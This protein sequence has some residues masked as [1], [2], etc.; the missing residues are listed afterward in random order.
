V[1]ERFLDTEEVTCS[2]H[3]P[4]TI[5]KAHHIKR[6]TGRHH[7]QRGAF[8]KV[9]ANRWEH[10]RRWN[11][12]E[13]YMRRFETKRLVAGLGLTLAMLLPLVAKP[14]DPDSGM[15][16]LAVNALVRAYEGFALGPDAEAPILLEPFTVVIKQYGGL[17]SIAL[18]RHSTGASYIVVMDGHSNVVASPK[19]DSPYEGTILLPGVIAGEIIA[20]YHY[21]LEDTGLPVSSKERLKRGHYDLEYDPYS[22]SV[23][24]LFV[25]ANPLFRSVLLANEPTATPSPGWTCLAGACHG[26]L[27]YYRVYFKNGQIVIEHRA[28]L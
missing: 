20:A 10:V 14:A 27:A 5:G 25:A 7:R 3:V 8:A 6:A 18:G 11:L 13:T 19:A 24:L 12:C 16:G 9:A 1:G 2:I 15:S 21:A 28:I 4:P 17:F 23:W 22:T 26:E